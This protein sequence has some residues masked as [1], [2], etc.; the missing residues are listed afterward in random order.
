MAGAF[1]VGDWQVD[2][3][4]RTLTC[5]NRQVQVE[6][7]VMQVLEILA[8]KGG[9]LVPKEELLHS[10][11]PDTFVGDEVLARV[12]SELRRVFGDDPRTPRYIQTIPKS[13]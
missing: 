9:R 11:W 5:G 1:S 13:A 10:A 12:V 4:L 2:P 6:P 3:S 7:K 8:G